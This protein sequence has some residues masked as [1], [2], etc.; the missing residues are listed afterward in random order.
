MLW[1]LRFG[2]NP[3]AR[4]DELEIITG[5]SEKVDGIPQNAVVDGAS[6]ESTVWE[7][8]HA[9]AHVAIIENIVD[10]PEK[11][12]VGSVIVLRKSRVTAGVAVELHDGEAPLH[13]QTER[14]EHRFDGPRNGVGLTNAARCVRDLNDVMY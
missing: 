2:A 8:N 4:P 10:S 5:N 7:Q 11:G 3:I 14:R 13:G 12:S 9:C 1:R 6:E